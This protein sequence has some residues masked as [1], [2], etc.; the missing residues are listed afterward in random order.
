[1]SILGLHHITIVCADAARTEDYYTGTLGF[2]VVSRSRSAATHDRPPHLYFALG[3]GGPAQL[4]SF[5]EQPDTPAGHEGV[6]GTHHFALLVETRA[7]LLQL[8]APAHRPRHQ[9]ERPT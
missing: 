1:M 5:L 4:V 6:G 8:E 9:R 2:R 7:A 3:E